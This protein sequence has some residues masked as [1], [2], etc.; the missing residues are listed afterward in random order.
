MQNKRIDTFIMFMAVVFMGSAVFIMGLLP[1]L[2]REHE[3]A[4]FTSA[5]AAGIATLS[6]SVP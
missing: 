1:W 4:K 3:A 2:G 6:T 5:K